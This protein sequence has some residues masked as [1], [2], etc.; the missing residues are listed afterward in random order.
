MPHHTT[1][2]GDEDAVRLAA[3]SGSGRS[4]R[5]AVVDEEVPLAASGNSNKQEAGKKVS[6]GAAAALAERRALAE[7]KQWLVEWGNYWI[8][9]RESPGEVGWWCRREGGRGWGNED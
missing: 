4:G 7:S 6:G 8:K 9:E 3:E 1:V 2:L 5:A